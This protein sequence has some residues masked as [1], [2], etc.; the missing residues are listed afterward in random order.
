MELEN[1]EEIFML[2]KH[3]NFDKIYTLIKSAQLTDLDFRDSNYNY[4]IQYIINYNQYDILKIILELSTNNIINIRLD[5][6][7][8]DGRSL[9]YNCIKFN[10]LELIK[11][12]IEYNKITIGISILDLKDNLGLSALH[13]SVIFNNLDSF[14]LLLQNDAD[15]YC[16]S[17]DGSNVFIIALMYKRTIILNYLLDKNFN[18]NF[19]TNT[20]ETLIQMAVNYQNYQIINRLLETSINLNNASTNFGLSI[21]HQSIILNNIDLFKKLLHKNIDINL[22]DFYGNTPLHYILTD[23]KLEYLDE[24]F[25]L[26]LLIKFNTSNIN[27]DT[28]LHI[29]LDLDITLINNNILTKIILETDL[30]I[31]N[32]QGETCL[33]KMANKKIIHN[34]RD[35]LIIKPLNF[36]IEDINFQHIPITD[37]IIDIMVDSYYNQIKIN[38][39]E[40]LIDWEIWCSTDN[41][42]KLVNIITT[43]KKHT[44][45]D[46]CKQKIK[47][48]I[49]KEKR[50]LPKVTNINLVFDNGI[51]INGCYY[52]GTP[53]DILCGLILLYQDFKLKGLNIILDYPLTTNTELAKYYTKIGLDYP[54]KLDF[55]NIEIIWSYQK[56]FL[57][58][59]FNDEI[60]KKIK[61][62]KYIVIPIGIETSVGSHANILFL[63]IQQ[64]T[65]ERFEPNGSNF[66]LGLNYNPSLLDTILENIF[67]NI[68][69]DIQYF[70]PNSF[71]PPIGFQIL[72]NLESDKCKKIGDPNGFCAVWCVW[73]IY[74]RMINI[75]NEKYQIKNIANQII[76]YIKFDN[77]SFKKIIRNFSKKITQIRDNF[78][79]K[80]NLDINDWVVGNYT[81]DNLNNLEKDIFKYVVNRYLYCGSHMTLTKY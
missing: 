33:M 48:I 76:K 40:L 32:N 9:L 75:D 20:G 26:P 11:L 5:I 28:P 4:F 27:G 14:K 66:P 2:I 57:P 78:L 24:F 68:I 41:Y 35:L 80:Y 65:I 49:I 16:M 37:D 3:K 19:T 21:L 15:P 10:Y 56:L 1:N 12:L 58:S 50:T 77:Q 55:S 46:I 47:E 34:F 7:D 70:P 62:S 30:N 17:K 60:N 36:Y 23:K 69:Q 42:N 71:L 25:K 67:K 45:S 8:T 59:Y 53:L 18:I 74:Q 43:D 22:P 81:Q 61:N 79:K 38:K 64:N 54:Y 13:Y 31:Q 39:D 52:T 44:S 72:E 6:L 73:W 63:D 29:L 51:F